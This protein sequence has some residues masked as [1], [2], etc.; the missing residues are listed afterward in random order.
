MSTLTN[1]EIAVLVRRRMGTPV[2]DRL[3]YAPL[4][5]SALLLLARDVAKDKHRRHLMLTDPA[6]TTVT[7]DGSGV[8]N[9]TALIASP[10]ILLPELHYGQIFDPSNPNPLVE[11]QQ[12]TRA[13]NWDTIYLH[14][15]LDG[16]LLRTQSTDNNATPLVGP[17]TLA[18][19]Y[20][21][22]LALL[23]DQLVEPLVE[24]CLRLLRENLAVYEQKEAE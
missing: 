12:S 3:R 20:W 9:L 16:V 2:S 15:R 13:G 18:V 6:T 17:L 4:I 24:C 22:S 19:P 1:A 14:Y 10:R 11:R 23:N 21:S 7:L 5:N 8:A